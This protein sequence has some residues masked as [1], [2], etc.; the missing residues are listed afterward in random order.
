MD[1]VLLNFY[2]NS[3]DEYVKKN[4][5]DGSI[6]LIVEKKQFNYIIK[7]KDRAGGIPVEILPKIFDAYFSTK[8]KNGN[9]IGLY[10]TK[11]IIEN[12][13]DGSITVYNEN[14]GCIFEL[15]LPLIN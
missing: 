14:E 4:I 10:M 6:E 15:I 5:K 7:I 3:L 2:K 9:G 11:S 12:S 8:S 1:Q 13:L